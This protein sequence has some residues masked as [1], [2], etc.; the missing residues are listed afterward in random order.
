MIFT[1]CFFFLNKVCLVRAVA[2]FGLPFVNGVVAAFLDFTS[3]DKRILNFKEGRFRLYFML[4]SH[5]IFN[6]LRVH[7]I[8]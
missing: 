1:Y 3:P 2:L 8:S 7:I 6:L 4:K 5:S